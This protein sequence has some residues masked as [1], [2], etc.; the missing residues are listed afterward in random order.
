M[1]ALDF[2]EIAMAHVGTERDQFEL[3]ARDFLEAE[4]FEI[5]RGPDQ[6]PDA[7]P[8]PDR[9]GEASGTRGRVDV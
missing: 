3:F 8:R 1:P 4:G 5:V 6:G 9:T 2:K 7:R